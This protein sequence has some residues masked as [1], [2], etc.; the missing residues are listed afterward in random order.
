V[1]QKDWHKLLKTV[2][3]DFLIA[4][5][6]AEAIDSGT[7]VPSMFST[8]VTIG[9]VQAGKAVS[10]L[11]D[12]PILQEE[13]KCWARN[14]RLSLLSS[15]ILMANQ[16]LKEKY[17][18]L[19]WQDKDPDRQAV[20]CVIFQMRCAFVHSS[21]DP[22]WKVSTRYQKSF[23]FSNLPSGPITLNFAQLNGQQFKPSQ[24]GEWYKVIEL[25]R[26]AHTNSI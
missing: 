22:W 14:V 1:V 21:Y 15:W 19:P 2:E 5:S 11:R 26:Y 16:A 25:L 13:L 23:T 8:Q 12:R 7:I 9:D 24:L 3:E 4:Q 17:S 18:N 10:V 20:R 6:M